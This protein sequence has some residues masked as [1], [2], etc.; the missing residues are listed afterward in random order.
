[1]SSRE[2]SERRVDL[3]FLRQRR[4]DQCAHDGAIRVPRELQFDVLFDRGDT[5]PP[6]PSFFERVGDVR[7][8]LNR[9]SCVRLRIRTLKTIGSIRRVGRLTECRRLSDSPRVPEVRKPVADA[10]AVADL[11]ARHLHV[12]ARDRVL[13]G[14]WRSSG[15]RRP[16]QPAPVGVFRAVVVEWRSR[17]P[18][19]P[20]DPPR[21]T[22]QQLRRQSSPPAGFPR[23]SS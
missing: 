15:R 23:A 3:C 9:S 16:G 20:A 4:A 2:A 6:D 13:C 7:L 19:G 11:L 8:Y 5:G 1:M 12:A 21:S 10:E 22:R 18:T 14:V 17:T